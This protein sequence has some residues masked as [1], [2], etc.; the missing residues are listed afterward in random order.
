MNLNLLNKWFQANVLHPG[1]LAELSAIAITYLVAWQVAKRLRGYLEAKIKK[2]QHLSRFNLN[3]ARFSTI[4]K[5][6]L[7]PL[8]LWLCQVVFNQNGMT[9]AI[10]PT[11]LKGALLFLAYRFTSWYI[12][13]VFWSRFLIIGCLL[14]I[15][16]RLTDLWAPTLQ[17][18]DS[19][20][21]HLGQ[22]QLSLLGIA[23]T[24]FTFIVLSV[25]ATI[26]N[27]FLSF[28][29]A[30]S[31]VRMNY[32]DRRLM[33]EVIR[34]VL[35]VVVVLVTL[36]SAGVHLA[37]LT[38]AGGAAGFA[39]G[40]GLQK[41]GS[42]LVAGI[43]LLTRKPIT[44][45]DVILIEEGS[46]SDS[47]I[48]QVKEIGLMYV[49]LATRSG[50]EELIPN[51]TFIT[52][53]I[54]H[55]S[56]SKKLRLRIPFGI[57][58]AS[59]LNRAMALAKEAAKSVGRV[60]TDPGPVCRLKKMGDSAIDLELRVWIND[61]MGGTTNLKS[62]VLLAVW[63][64]FHANDIEFAFPQQDLHIKSSVPL[65]M[66]QANRQQALKGTPESE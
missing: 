32:S 24:A 26:G 56:R 30:T 17:M 28:M 63:E 45:G 42:N 31:A 50:T 7:W 48:G 58:Y 40:V 52:H 36:A 64:N 20:T 66:F 19:M 65:E 35:M 23:K 9:A 34:F 60:L 49:Q 1:F 29:L 16:L 62:A 53:K 44:Q 22:I 15:G 46:G 4:V 43:A 18:L 21:I 39:V 51:E 55:T 10:F 33:E 14:F 47:R 13:S 41:V 61:P 59:D 12:R 5:Y 11:A 3:P 25:A 27:H 38:V 2:T 37:A 6:L 8:L 54:V 57:S